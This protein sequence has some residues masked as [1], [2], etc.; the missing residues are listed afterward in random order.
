MRTMFQSVH[1]VGLKKIYTD[2][3]NLCISVVICVL[4]KLNAIAAF[5]GE[6]FGYLAA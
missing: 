3:A 4:K 2:F 6:G 1:H 5:G